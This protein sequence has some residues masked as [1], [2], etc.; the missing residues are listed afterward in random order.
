MLRGVFSGPA[1]TELAENNNET[2]QL[3][4]WFKGIVVNRGEEPLAPRDLIPMHE[5][6]TR[7]EK[8]S[9]QKLEENTDESN[10]SSEE[11][12]DE[13]LKKEDKPLGYDQQVDVKT[14]LS[15]GPMFSEVR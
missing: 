3:D 11:N 1:A 2:K 4:E 14:T 15:R 6:L 7:E 10:S 5:P 9:A 8:E 13:A 12:A